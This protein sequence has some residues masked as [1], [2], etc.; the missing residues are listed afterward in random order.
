MRKVCGIQTNWLNACRLQSTGLESAHCKFRPTNCSTNHQWLVRWRL[1]LSD[2]QS[3]TDSLTVWWLLPVISARSI[4]GALQSRGVNCCR[5]M[6]LRYH[7]NSSDSIR[8]T[9]LSISVCWIDFHL[10]IPPLTPKTIPRRLIRSWYTGRLWVGFMGASA[11]ERL[12]GRAVTFGTATRGLCGLRPRS[13]P[14]SLYQ[15]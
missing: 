13:V 14:S 9:N 11:D 4:T 6:Q 7:W 1:W 8:F 2:W 10:A 5:L 15:I 3:G 12:Y